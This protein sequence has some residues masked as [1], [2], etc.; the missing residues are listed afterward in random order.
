[1][2]H[3]EVQGSDSQL[4]EPSMSTPY[5][6]RHAPDSSLLWRIAEYTDLIERSD[7]H[8]VTVRD[9]VETPYNEF[10]II[11]KQE[12]FSRLLGSVAS[13]Y[14][15][16]G[17]FA[18]PHHLYWPRKHFNY[19]SVPRSREEVT[20][21]FRGSTSLKIILPRE[22]HDYL[23]RITQL[24][25]MPDF[26]VMEQYVLEQEQVHKLYNTVR[27]SSLEKIDASFDIK[28][29][30]RYHS[31]LE[32]LSTMEDGHVGL[33][34]SRE[35]LALAPVAESRQILRRLAQPM[36]ISAHRACQKAFFS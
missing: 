11:D 12:L 29:L 26:E 27:F 15:W 28:E 8:S 3:A 30:I 9:Y 32:K 13:E 34:P 14:H 23:H 20:A 21:R 25:D 16:D 2:I 22:L 36:G 7:N 31:I 10:G 4:V 17:S 19:P 35:T 24:P 33:M 18:G 5:T 6:I 1:M